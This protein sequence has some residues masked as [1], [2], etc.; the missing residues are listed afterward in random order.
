MPLRHPGLLFLITWLG[1]VYLTSC[2]PI[3]SLIHAPPPS[4][5][6]QESVCQACP[7]FT[8]SEHLLYLFCRWSGHSRPTTGCSSQ[9]IH[10]SSFQPSITHGLICAL[11]K[12]FRQ[13]KQWNGLG[14]TYLTLLGCLLQ[15]RH[16]RTTCTSCGHCS[17]SCCLRSSQAQRSLM[18]GSMSRTR[19]LRQRLSASCTRWAAACPMLKVICM[20]Q[21]TE[22]IHWC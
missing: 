18:S 12:L 16:C 13:R 22:Y 20:L 8:V 2:C 9:V 1:V 10:T 3:C 17:T 19:T 21:C 4:L 7:L 14:G 11:G 6:L 15:E 5:G